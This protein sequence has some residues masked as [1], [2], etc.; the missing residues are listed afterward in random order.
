MFRSKRKSKN[1][2]LGRT[3]NVLHV[4][5]RSSQ[6][7]ASRIRLLALALSVSLGTVAGL[8][9]LWRVGEWTLDRFVYENPAFAIQTVDVQ[10][11]GVI[12]IDQL[13][14]W[15]GVKLGQNLFALD[16]G[17]VKRA[18]ELVPRIRTASVERIL[19]GT[20]RLRVAEREPVAQV[21]IPRPRSGG[22]VDLVVYQL[23]AEGYVLQPLDPRQRAAPAAVPDSD[24]AL[25]LGVDA[26]KLQP[27]RRVESV[28][29]QGALHLINAFAG[30]AL[31]GTVEL[32]R[33]DVSQPGVLVVTSGQGS[34]ITFGLDDFD[35]QLLRW[36]K[37]HEECLKLNKI[38]GM[39]DL[40]VADNPPLRVMEAGLLPQSIPKNVKLPRTR[41][42]NV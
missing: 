5:L 20:L 24:L 23:D 6:L 30:T 29:V 4:K 34:E 31:A 13:K 35:R 21:N 28:P 10:T 36:W 41:K 15:S 3:Q 17:G 16:L 11:D 2:R 38:I 19:P 27:G 42:K 26:S 39:L 25:L 9:A 1:R 14:G 18:L 12:A 8:Y 37:V 22:G 7:R 32:R 33:V 40:A